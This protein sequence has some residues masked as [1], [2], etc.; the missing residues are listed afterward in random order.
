MLRRGPFDRE[1]KPRR[2]QV[3]RLMHEAFSATR[4]RHDLGWGHLGGG[5]ALLAMLVAAAFAPVPATRGEWAFASFVGICLTTVLFG[6]TR[7]VLYLF[8]F[9][10]AGVARYVARS[11]VL[12][13]ANDWVTKRAWRIFQGRA[14]GMADAP[15]GPRGYIVQA[16]ATKERS[17]FVLAE[18]ISPRFIAKARR[19]SLEP[20]VQLQQFLWARSWSRTAT[21]NL[22]KVLMTT[23]TLHSSY[24]RDARVVAQIADW[25]AGRRS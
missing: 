9:Q 11:L 22:W 12:W 18:E 3:F 20:L 10:V 5:I 1:E 14:T 23:D 16:H 21:K 4:F 13:Y 24:Y 2:V 8:P 15:G 7:S 25:I 17:R 6:L 19:R